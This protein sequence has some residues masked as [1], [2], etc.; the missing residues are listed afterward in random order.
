MALSLTEMTT[1]VSG[2][3]W[4]SQI[5]PTCNRLLPSVLLAVNQTAPENSN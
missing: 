2:V 4:A 1:L 3:S 5:K